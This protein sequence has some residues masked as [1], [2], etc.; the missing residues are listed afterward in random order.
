MDEEIKRLQ[1]EYGVDEDTAEQ[2]REFI[3]EG[4]G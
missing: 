3:D 2:A 4:L 1:K